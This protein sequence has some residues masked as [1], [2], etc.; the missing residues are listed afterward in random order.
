[1]N[2][3]PQSPLSTRARMLIASAAMLGVFLG[4]MALIIIPPF[5]SQSIH[6]NV[7]QGEAID[8]LDMDIMDLT[9]LVAAL[10][11]SSVTT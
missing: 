9:A 5:L 3:R 10:G 1:M 4:A 6:T 8:D 2:R 11:N 7:R